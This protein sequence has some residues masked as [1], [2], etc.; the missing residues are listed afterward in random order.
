[1]AFIAST[2]FRAVLEQRQARNPERKSS[3]RVNWSIHLT[4]NGAFPRELK[5]L[6][7]VKIGAMTGSL[8]CS[9][10]VGS[11]FLNICTIAL[12]SEH[13][14]SA[15]SW[16]VW[17]QQVK[18]GCSTLMQQ[19]IPA[20]SLHLALKPTLIYI[21]GISTHKSLHVVFL[22]IKFPSPQVI[23]CI[24][25]LPLLGWQCCSMKTLRL[26]VLLL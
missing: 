9:M 24:V 3:G 22:L 15:Q 14:M 17:I 13:C 12:G 8:T 16:A 4:T 20:R 18:E 6:C 10:V 1:M 21:R 25:Y 19:F 11:V 26:I 7:P 23:I 2:S 5:S